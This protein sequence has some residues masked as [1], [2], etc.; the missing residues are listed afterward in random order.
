MALNLSLGYS[1]SN[2]ATTLT[3]TDT[4]GT[5]VVTDNETGW[6]SPNEV[7]TDIVAGSDVINAGTETHLLLTVTVTDKTGT[8]TVYDEINLYDHDSTGPFAD[9]S[10]L[11]WDFTPIV[12]E[13]AGRTQSNSIDTKSRA[14]L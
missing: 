9:A 14:Q 1:Q 2:D 6:G 13:H 10:D 5:Y 12:N 11:T 3:I 4:A 8:A 7:V